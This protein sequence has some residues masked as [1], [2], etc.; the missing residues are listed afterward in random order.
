[1]GIVLLVALTAL[2]GLLAGC[3]SS[4]DTATTD[5][6]STT[7]AASP[8]TTVKGKPTAT[9]VAPKT[10]KSAPGTTEA[11]SP[12][13]D[14]ATFCKV[15]KVINFNDLKS[16]TVFDHAGT[17]KLVFNFQKIQDAAPA[18]ILPSLKDMRVLVDALNA[19]VKSGAVHDLPSF[20]A[21][22]QKLNETK[23][24]TIVRWIK[25]QQAMVPY[26]KQHCPDN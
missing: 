16:F 18:D 20:E 3:G 6:T 25:G 13:G 21:W 26:L 22:V 24:D 9:P 10:P 1:V 8:T 15:A 12:A 14:L 7:A 19:Q 4:A 23:A 5:T 2:A 11:P 17:V